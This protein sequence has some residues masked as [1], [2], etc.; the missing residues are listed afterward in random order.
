MVDTQGR[1]VPL[2]ELTLAPVQ[3]A[4]DDAFRDVD[5]T[6]SL[7]IFSDENGAFLVPTIVRRGSWQIV[8][9]STRAT[10]TVVVIESSSETVVRFVVQPG[11]R[12]TGTVLDAKGRGLAGVSVSALTRDA[13]SNT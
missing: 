1:P 9:G 3:G 8:P 11:L 5:A 2:E 12:I 4:L 6:N 10:P 7:R 13:S